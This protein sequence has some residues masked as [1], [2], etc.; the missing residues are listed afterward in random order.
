MRCYLLTWRAVPAL[1]VASVMRGP[2]KPGLQ[3]CIIGEDWQV[4][5]ALGLS[6]SLLESDWPLA[7]HAGLGCQLWSD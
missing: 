2:G 3:R 7:Q 1:T 4:M 5:H 6:S